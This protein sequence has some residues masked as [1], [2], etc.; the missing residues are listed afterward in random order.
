MEDK[1]ISMYAL[2]LSSIAIFFGIVAIITSQPYC[3]GIDIYGIIVTL[4]IGMITLLIGWQIFNYL[5][6]KETIKEVVMSEVEKTTKDYRHVLD[7]ITYMYGHAGMFNGNNPAKL[8]HCGVNS[9][10]ESLMCQDEELKM[11]SVEYTMNFLHGVVELVNEDERNKPTIYKGKRQDYLYL[12]KYVDNK[13]TEELI[14]FISEAEETQLSDENEI[15]F[16]TTLS[17]EDIDSICK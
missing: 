7:A 13:Y 11:F 4:L 2:I 14:E 12:L 9:L 6:L 15:G 10:R 16:M 8:V 1:N 17:E 5:S 3:I